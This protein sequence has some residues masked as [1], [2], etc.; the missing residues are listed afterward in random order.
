MGHNFWSQGGHKGAP[1]KGFD[2]FGMSIKLDG[3]QFLITIWYNIG[4][5]LGGSF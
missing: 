5:T 2:G 1:D 3:S 4:I